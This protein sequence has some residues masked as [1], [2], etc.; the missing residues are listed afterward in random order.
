[1]S[2]APWQFTVKPAPGRR[3]EVV[4]AVFGA[5]PLTDAQP[6]ARDRFGVPPAAPLEVCEVRTVTRAVDPAWFDAWRSGSLRAI[7]EGDLGADL[8][9]LDAA[10]HVHLVSVSVEAPADLS[11]LQVAW[12]L[13]RYL[14]MRGA[15]TVLDVH[16]MTF[17]RGTALPPPEAALD[18]AREVRRVYETT[19]TREDLAHALHTRG[20]RKFGAAEL[21]ALCGDADARLVGHVIGELADAVARG[22][23][24]TGP[25]HP[26]VIAPGVTWFVVADEHHLGALLQ[27]D[28]RACVL[29]DDRGRDLL[30]VIGRLPRGSA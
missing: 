6:L 21:I 7:A 29:V 4:L 17:V 5:G 30:G 11:Y 2:I 14:V 20:M 15:T 22:A 23:E 26:V 27:L 1:M 13:A 10:D 24:I 8:A 28:N 18:V 25:R 19:S 12:G 3:P 9:Q 16:A